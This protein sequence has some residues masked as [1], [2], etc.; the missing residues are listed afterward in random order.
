MVIPGGGLVV[1][2]GRGGICWGGS[3]SYKGRDWECGG[4]KSEVGI[5]GGYMEM[6]ME[7]IGLFDNFI[8][9]DG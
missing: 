4:Q 1:G 9:N 6:Y 5:S 7:G 3:G 2:G 8:R